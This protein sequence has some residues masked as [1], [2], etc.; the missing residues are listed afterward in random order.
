M[1]IFD[2]DY[3]MFKYAIADYSTNYIERAFWKS[4]GMNISQQIRD[5]GIS[6]V[7]EDDPMQSVVK[8]GAQYH[9]SGDEFSDPEIACCIVQ[10]IVYELVQLG[11][12]RLRSVDAKLLI[13]PTTFEAI[14][15][16]NARIVKETPIV[17]EN[18]MEIL[19][20]KNLTGGWFIGNFEPTCYKTDLCEVAY[21]YHY[22]GEKTLPHY[23][24]HCDEI[25]YLI[26][27]KIQINGQVMEAPCVFILKAGEIVYPEFLTSC[28]MIVV[29]PGGI[30][31]DKVIVDNEELR[32]TSITTNQWPG[33]ISPT[34]NQTL[35][36]YSDS[37][38]KSGVAEYKTAIFNTP[39]KEESEIT[40]NKLS[41]NMLA[42]VEVL[43]DRMKLPPAPAT[44]KRRNK[45]Q[46]IER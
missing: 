9:L 6:I 22:S 37:L 24:R 38:D 7:S 2:Q 25:N 34:F 45:L 5:K 19:D 21:K 29:K 18:K 36:D 8:L 16:F 42:A 39:I 33:P 28:T 20:V 1:E 40:A 17:M 3:S 26:T 46:T 41:A 11:T 30:K 12:I 14:W 13:D 31:G 4:I 44:R 35:S 27:G 15:R 23:H 43:R 10:E 32:M